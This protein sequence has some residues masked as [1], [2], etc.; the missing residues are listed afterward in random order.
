MIERLRLPLLLLG[1]TLV[2]IFHRLL[3]GE[4]F[5]WGLPALQFYPW[6][7]YAVELLGNG[8][9]PLW[10]PYNG[11]GAPLFANYQSALLYP[12]NWLSFVLPLE[13][14]MSVMAVLH[15]AFAG[16][17]MWA[18]TGRLGLSPLGR[19]VS[20]LAFALTGYLVGRLGTFPIILTAA[21][22]PW[23][24]W[25]A[26]GL[27]T[28]FRRRDGAL[29]A[30]FSGLMLLA[31]HA[32][33][34][35]YTLLL[36]GLFALWFGLTQQLT[37]PFTWWW[38]RLR[39]VAAVAALLLLGAGLAA[40]QLIPTAELLLTSQR[41]DGVDFDF[42]MNFSYHPLRSLNLLSPYI[43]G[44]PVNGTYHEQQGVF[45]EFAV[46][47][48]LIPLVAAIAALLG[49]LRQRQRDPA[50]RQ[51]LFTSVPFWAIIVIVGVV[52]ALGRHTPVYPFL[53]REVPTFDLF[54]APVRWHLWTVTALSVLA[55][56]G[57][58]HWGRDVRLK[59]WT[60]LV[61]VACIGVVVLAVIGR[62]LVTAENAGV[63]ILL[64]AMIRTGSLAAAAGLLTLLQ[65][66]PTTARHGRWSLLVLI[67]IAVDLGWAAWGLNPTVP[68]LE[69]IETGE[70]SGR[71]IYWQQDAERVAFDAAFPIGDYPAAVADWPT[72]R[73]L[74]LPNMNLLDRQHYLNNFDPLRVGH[75][76]GYLDWIERAQRPTNLLDAA[77]VDLVFTLDD[78]G[79]TVR[80]IDPTTVPPRARLIDAV[81]WHTSAE[82]LEAA[83]LDRTWR[84][85]QQLHMLGDGDCA[86]PQPVDLPTNAL[87][88]ND[89]A[90]RVTITVDAPRFMWL[91]LADVHYPGWTA[92]VDGE[93]VP[94]YPANG[95]FRAVQVRPGE[96]TVT[97]RYAAWWL[98]PGALVSVTA[99]V[100]ILVLFR[101]RAV[102]ARPTDS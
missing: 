21:W 23:L 47:T 100:L 57:V 44:S 32:Q 48:G 6:R 93:R 15:L 41:G 38:E 59:R 89:S 30:L 35:W 17:G 27:L 33:T 90:N 2:V 101:S 9:L 94:I 81:C 13:L 72:T 78:D 92:A 74:N 84:P 61:T 49:W 34:S 5:F 20:T 64:D 56:I 10:N 58:S 39:R 51:S 1:A 71:R 80:D 98:L 63:R 11:A 76:E 55:G 53:F 40:L 25:A 77:G 14:M 24:L 83:L 50:E 31:G 45:F 16:W 8:Q 22:L 37:P 88:L 96:Q 43:F 91:V 7:D 75:F 28:H 65:P 19:G 52:F 62:L 87:L 12:P 82:S 18:F 86:A 68:A 97:F 73:T 67:V 29:L 36:V 102:P 26:V 99:L 66:D 3:L 46:Y 85:D 60:R 4:V 42:A 69:R 70:R 54:Q 95:V 79:V